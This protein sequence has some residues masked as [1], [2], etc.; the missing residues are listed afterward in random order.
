MRKIKIWILK[1]LISNRNLTL[2]SL[3]FGWTKAKIENGYVKKVSLRED[4]DKVLWELFKQ[5]W[6]GNFF[7]NKNILNKSVRRKA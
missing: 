1:K 5:Q 7:V 3:R 4:M 2:Y 6:F